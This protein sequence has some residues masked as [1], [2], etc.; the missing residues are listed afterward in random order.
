[1]R[2][3]GLTAIMGQTVSMIA[4]RPAAGCADGLERG[5]RS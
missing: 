4:S 5:C 2:R 1:M 3:A